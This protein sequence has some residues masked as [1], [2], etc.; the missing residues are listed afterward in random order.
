[1]GTA[2]SP[3]GRLANWRG[4]AAG[5]LLF[6]GL[7]VTV[8]SP[9]FASPADSARAPAAVAPAVDIV[10]AVDTTGSMAPSIEQARE[11]AASL[12][13]NVRGRHSGAR[14]GLIQFRD[15]G[16]DPE[17]ELVH[18]LTADAAQLQAGLDRLEAA[19]GGDSPEAYNLVFKN[20]LEAQVGWRARSRRLLVVLGDAEPHGAG[21]E[22]FAGCSDVS[23]DP[24]GLSSTTELEKLKAAKTTLLMVLQDSSH[25]SAG[26]E[27]YRSLAAAA[28]SGGAAR[29]GGDDLTSV[30]E[31]LIEDAI[32]EYVALGDSYSSGE[33]NPP[34]DK[35]GCHRSAA[36]W[37][38]QLVAAMRDV[39]LTVNIAC[40]GAKLGALTAPYKGQKAQVK[41]LAELDADLVTVTI[42]GNDAKFGPVLREC[43]LRDCRGMLKANEAKVTALAKQL[44][45]VFA[46][47]KAAVN[48][49]TRVVVVGY[50]RIFPTTQA[51]TVKCGWLEP[52][53]RKTLN[54]LG[55]RLDSIE[56][57]AAEQA[58]VEFISVLNA[59]DGHELCTKTSWMFRLSVTCARDTKCGHP[60]K[61][62][63]KAIADVVRG[64]LEP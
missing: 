54:R 23:E 35:T 41:A 2:A 16:D 60:L 8:A 34:F 55:S 40:T 28:F 22:G 6:T 17:Y 5:L 7:A 32:V 49:E 14:F 30:I 43:L 44:P 20:S 10:I 52:H 62:G 61:Q 29:S 3:P 1:M 19:E 26:L 21:T 18:A 15:S 64:V 12:V 63:Q 31:E 38:H 50:P 56:K 27:C 33:G 47:I 24:N 59:L 9:V 48:S 42:G 53:E 36:S 11:D 57:A 37:P 25:T 51:K 13:A 39:T 46:R 58:G 45:P 4:A